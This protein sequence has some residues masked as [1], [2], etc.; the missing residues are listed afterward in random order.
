[1]NTKDITPYLNCAWCNAQAYRA[2]V[3]TRPQFFRFICP[4]KHSTFVLE[5]DFI[6]NEQ[7]REI[8]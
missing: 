2:A 4:A 5:Q 8:Q 6:H 3:Q 7:E 1:M